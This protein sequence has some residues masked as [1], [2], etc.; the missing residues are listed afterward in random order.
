MVTS[1]GEIVVVGAGIVGAAIALRL[2]SEGHSVRLVDRADPGSG[3][4]F[5]NMACIAV[6]EF[7]PMS[8]PGI[9]RQLPRWFLDSEGPVHLRAGALGRLVPWLVRFMKAGLPRRREYLKRSGASLCRRAE[10]DF[11]ALLAAAGAVDL[12][13]DLEGALRVYLSERDAREDSEYVREVCELGFDCRLLNHHQIRELE[14]HLAESVYGGAFLPGWLQVKDPFELVQRVVSSFVSRGGIVQRA[15]VT[16]FV[17]ADRVVSKVRV[18][19]GEDLPAANTI[20]A[21][22]AWTARLSKLLHDPIPLE[23]ERGYHTQ[24]A[25][26]GVTL[27]RALMIPGG[28]FAITPVTDGIRVGG[29]VELGGLEAPANFRRAKVLVRRAKELL[30]GLKDEDCSE[31]MGHR[32]ALPDTIPVIG[33]ATHFDNVYYATGHGHLGLTLAATTAVLINELMSGQSPSTD[34]VPFNP[35]RF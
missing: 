5:G 3:A 11:R 34:L 19:S 13:S 9:W 31:W 32:P 2:Q 29:T 7:L 17:A 14:P 33:K 25:N 10:K 22:G 21:C 23:T 12:V 15:E 6:T 1:R 20:L 28:G 30:P 26:P 4:S 8:R 35:G 27:R 24:I 16:G 18:S